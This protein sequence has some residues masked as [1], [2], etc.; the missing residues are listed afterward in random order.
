MSQRP[1]LLFFADAGAAVGGGHVMRC[2]ALA[3][4]LIRAGGTCAFAATPTAAAILDAF[5]GPEIERLLLPDETAARLAAPVGDRA[6]SW[7]AHAAVVDH[8]GLGIA[9][10]MVV[11][12]SVHYLAVI[13]DLKRPHL[14]DLV[15]D[16]NLD[17][18]PGDYPGVEALLGPAFALLRPA[19]AAHR[20][21][22]LARRVS[23]RAPQ[24]LLIALGLTDVDGITGRVVQAVAPELGEMTADVV[25]GQGAA[26]L[27][28][29]AA[30]ARGD[31]RLIL[32][33]DTRDMADLT[34]SAD[35]AIG[36]GGSSVWERC[37]LGL[38]ALTL[39][40]ADN[41][42]GAAKALARRGAARV[43]E[44]ADPGFDAGLGAALAQLVADPLALAAMSRAAAAICD[45]LG[46]ERV[47][48][49]L[50]EGL[51]RK[52]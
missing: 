17:R 10:E 46:A 31:P 38:P 18:S 51:N 52:A 48:A 11:R 23:P 3:E 5:A 14:C 30:S 26:S 49:Y 37:C 34:A 45:G 27:P 47:A 15:L 6:R 24:R 28:R 12:G 13:D 43:L 2:L 20:P 8:Y 44:A 7:G 42:R 40:L 41:Q 50:I 19:F 39:V 29:L 4:A 21:A 35:L 16:S 36:A 22:A 33:I 1:R 9:E 25:V 32:H